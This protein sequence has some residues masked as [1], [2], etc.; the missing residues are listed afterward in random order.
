MS[1]QLNEHQVFIIDRLLSQKL[2]TESKSMRSLSLG[3]YHD[4]LVAKHNE[5]VDEAIAW[6]KRSSDRDDD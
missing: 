3:P 2:L 5:K 4:K 1:R 6:V